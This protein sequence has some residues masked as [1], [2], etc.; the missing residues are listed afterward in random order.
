M[1]RSMPRKMSEFRSKTHRAKRMEP[2][3]TNISSSAFS[4]VPHHRHQQ[5]SAS[6]STIHHS[7]AT[8]DALSL[9]RQDSPA[10]DGGF[11]NGDPQNSSLIPQNSPLMA[12]QQT[13]VVVSQQKSP[14]MARQSSPLVSKPQQPLQSL[15]TRE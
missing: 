14:V 2:Y 10:T 7:Q 15:Q 6:I 9:T 5:Q 1:H 11:G 12:H 8:S 3:P 4:S 13:S